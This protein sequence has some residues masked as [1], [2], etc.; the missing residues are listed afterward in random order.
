ADD[1]CFTSLSI[2]PNYL[3]K[4]AFGDAQPN[5]R[6]NEC[7][8]TTF[9]RTASANRG[10]GAVVKRSEEFIVRAAANQFGFCRVTAN[11]Q[12]MNIVAD[13]ALGIRID[14]AILSRRSGFDS[15]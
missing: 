7:D 9:V 12:V 13:R 5:G 2:A 15:D 6:R 4:L 10:G 3:S 14:R 8:I 11:S 1:F